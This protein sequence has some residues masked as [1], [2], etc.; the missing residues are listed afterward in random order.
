[1]PSTF[2]HP[3]IVLPLVKISGKWFSLTGLVIG[4]LVPDFEYFIRMRMDS[5]ISHTPAGLFLFDLPMGLMLTFVFHNIVRNRLYDN[6][7]P[8]LQR[9]VFQY[10]AFSWNAYFTHHWWIV[11]LSI[12]IGAASHLFWDGFTHNHAFFVDLFPVLRINMDILGRLT[13]LYRVLQ[14]VSSV[15]GGLVIVLSIL[16]MPEVKTIA[17]YRDPYYWIVV[18]FIAGI[19]SFLRL[20]FP[21]DQK[22]FPQIVVTIISA[23][24][25]AV[26]A[27]SVLVREKIKH[28]VR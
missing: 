21:L 12:L 25:I 17:G 23:T 19:I 28:D 8:S 13:P 6:L 2:S 11:A 4:S 9:R 24:L 15:I 7:P 1:M 18:V 22:V 3:A 27:A 20:S 16:R 10:K 26:I 14:H 5:R